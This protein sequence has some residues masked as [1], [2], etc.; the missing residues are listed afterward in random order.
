MYIL[1]YGRSEKSLKLGKYLMEN[2]DGRWIESAE[3]FS[4]RTPLTASEKNACIVMILPL[5]ACC[6]I[7]SDNYSPMIASLPVICVSPDGK[8]AAVLR[9]AGVMSLVDTDEIYRAI[10]D[11]LGRDCFT[12]FGDNSDFAPDL[13]KT[14]RAYNMTP[15]DPE[16][17]PMVNSYIKS[18][19]RVNVYT[20][21][22]VSFAEPVL[23]SLIF[24][25]NRYGSHTRD[26]FIEAYVSEKKKD[27]DKPA[28]FVTCTNLPD[29]EGEGR[30]LVLIPRRISIGLEIKDK[31]D[32]GYAVKYVRS[33]LVNHMIEP[34]AVATVAVT[35]SAHSSEIVRAI[36]DDLGA[37]VTAYSAKQLSEVVI[38]LQ[39]TFAPEKMH[40]VCTAAACLAS[41]DGNI[42]IRRAGGNSG[43]VFSASLQKGNIMMTE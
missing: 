28:V 34:G 40:E 5:E 14:A 33:T 21:L 16:L 19:G 25:V 37:S 8:F 1:C 20:D 2:L 35:Q 42:L 27:S 18:G 26:S 3:F 38:P 41:S 31:V 9:R 24:D 10:A 43:L 17:L 12:S 22:P 39:M 36:A 15:N 7:L 30:P 32:P 13:V 29:V 23:D 4:S 6:G 11:L